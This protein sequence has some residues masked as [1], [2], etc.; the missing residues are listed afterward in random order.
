MNPIH[1]ILLLTLG[2][3]PAPRHHETGPL[4]A[5]DFAAPAPADRGGRLAS[6]HTGFDYTFKYRGTTT[7]KGVRLV[8]TEFNVRAAVVPGKSWNLAPADARLMDHEQ[9]H[10]DITELH[11]RNWRRQAADQI[12]RQALVGEGATQDA[13][14]RALQERFEAELRSINKVWEAEQI[15]YDKETD[16]GRRPD[17]QVRWRQRLNR[18]L[19]GP[20]KPAERL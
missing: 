9:G 10:F 3:D 20:L 4:T 13:A 18:D 17:I 16:H 2:A 19:A 15:L 14:Y 8:A 7:D 5:A 11:A 6:T 1:L 12:A